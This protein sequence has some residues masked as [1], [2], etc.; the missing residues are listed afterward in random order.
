MDRAAEFPGIVRA[1]D[2]RLRLV[3]L[4]D[5]GEALAL[6]ERPRGSPQNRLWFRRVYP[7][8]AARSWAWR[9]TRDLPY[10]LMRLR[11]SRGFALPEEKPSSR[12]SPRHR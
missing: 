7:R 11:S 5:A 8:S 3:E 12:Q 1:V 4:R 6:M 9:L 2:Q 10:T